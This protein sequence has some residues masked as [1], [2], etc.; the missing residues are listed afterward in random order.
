M[1]IKNSIGDCLINALMTIIW[2][3]TI[4]MIPYVSVERVYTVILILLLVILLYW[5]TIHP[6]I[7]VLAGTA[8][9]A[10][11]RCVALFPVLGLLRY[12]WPAYRRMVRNIERDEEL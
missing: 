11:L 6:I 4:K 12:K 1:N 5:A 3:T 7:K 8:S 10:D 9:T 2:T